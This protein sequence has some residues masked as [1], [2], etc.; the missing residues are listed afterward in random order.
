MKIDKAYE[1]LVVDPSATE[2]ERHEAFLTQRKKL[3]A[4]LAKAPTPGLAQKYRDSLARMEQ[5]IEVIELA[6]DGGDLPA[7]R[8]DYE[9]K[10]ETTAEPVEQQSRSSEQAVVKQVKAKPSVK[11]SG[12]GNGKEILIAAV[13]VLLLIGAGAGWWFGYESP[14]RGEAGRLV[15]KAVHLEEKGKLSQAV[16]VFEKALDLKSGWKEAIT[17]VD[18]VQGELDRIE[19]EQLRNQER[20]AADQSRDLDR[21]LAKARMDQSQEKW[22]DALAGFQKAARIDAKNVEAAEAVSRLEKLLANARGSV[23][24]KTEPGGATV[25]L[26]GRGED[27]T[28]ANYVDLKLGSYT[29]E[30]EKTGYDMIEKEVLVRKDQTS[31][32][33]PLRLNRSEG[34]LLIKSEPEGMSY[35]VQRVSSDVSSDKEFKIRRGVTPAVESDMTT[36][37]YQVVMK[38]EGWPDYRRHVSVKRDQKDEVR[39][40][41]EER[42]K[43]VA[44]KKM[45]ERR[46][47]IERKP[48]NK[49]HE[50]KASI[51][52]PHGFSRISTGMKDMDHTLINTRIQSSDRT[53]AFGVYMLNVRSLS[54]NVNARKI[55]LPLKRGEKVVDRESSVRN[56][57]LD[58]GIRYQH[59]SEQITV[60]GPNHSYTRYFNLQVTTGSVPGAAS[61]LWELQVANDSAR[62][63]Y[64][65]IYRQFKGSLD[66]GEF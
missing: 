48:E 2:T 62:K 17:G 7:L 10:V 4:K 19:S 13:V 46:A 26:G 56:V 64:Q 54:E 6:A 61:V 15:T 14:R 24:V 23:V 21:L 60:S 3:E 5:A 47:A 66:G 35:T 32:L 49:H 33:G 39:T 55:Q 45:P 34:A 50:Y 8:P 20:Q 65:K 63:K 41:F 44:L 57:K 36:G 9:T 53:V 31:V 40:R 27:I 37:V 42:H 16:E 51:D 52:I 22:V 28:P 58:G 29:V 59:Y 18:R 30:I 43:K 1:T 12:V 11:S 38:R 25:R